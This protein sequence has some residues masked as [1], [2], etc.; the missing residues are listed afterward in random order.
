MVDTTIYEQPANELLRACLRVEHLF[1][2]LDYHYQNCISIYHVRITI[3]LLIEILNVLDRPDLKSKLSQEFQRVNAIFD[4]L[5]STPAISQEQ[6]EKTRQE[7]N[8]SVDYLTSIYGKLGQ[9]LREN[10]FINN[11]RNHLTANGGDSPFETPAYHRW[12]QLPRQEQYQYLTNWIQLLNP[13]R[14]SINLL[15]K[16]IRNS[17]QAEQ[18]EAQRGFYHCSLPTYPP[19]QLV[20]IEFNDQ[21]LSY[22]EISVGRHRLNVCFYQLNTEDRP[23]QLES[24]FN[25]KL[26]LCRI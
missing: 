2:Q 21:Y 3:R 5:E 19:I 25:F 9:S 11:I 20:L 8:Q 15:L 6:L 26:S 10:P 12:L 22:P 1:T 14:Q 17:T 16:I 4:K 13:I 23:E 18:V 7:L 24:D